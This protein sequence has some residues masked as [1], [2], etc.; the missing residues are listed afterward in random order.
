MKKIHMLD[1]EGMEFPA[2]RRTRVVLGETGVI[3]ESR[4]C[5]GYVVIYPGGSVPPHAHEAVETY[6]I[7]KGEGLMSVD[8][9]EARVVAGDLVYIAGGKPHGLS[10]P[11]GEDLHM[12]FVYSPGAAAEHWSSER[13]GEARRL[14][15]EE[16]K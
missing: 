10:N 1:L 9:E 7:I 16:K 12:M 13:A 14:D 4:F 6:T 2:G 8:G 15:R 5:Q 3:Q 11:G